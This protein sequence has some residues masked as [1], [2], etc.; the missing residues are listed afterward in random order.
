MHENPFIRTRDMAKKC[1]KLSFFAKNRTF[2]FAWMLNSPPDFRFF[3]LPIPPSVLYTPHPAG[4]QELQA[5]EG[6]KVAGPITPRGETVRARGCLTE[7]NY[8]V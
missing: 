4:L 8:I 2:V 6:G 1:E 7:N 5:A 3:S